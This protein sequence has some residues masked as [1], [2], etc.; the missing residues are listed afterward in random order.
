MKKLIR[1]AASINIEAY[2]PSLVNVAPKL[3][4]FICRGVLDVVS[5][6]ASTIPLVLCSPTQQTTAL[7]VPE[8]TNP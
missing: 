6:F 8:A 7:P 4:N 3:S 5:S 2:I 1:I